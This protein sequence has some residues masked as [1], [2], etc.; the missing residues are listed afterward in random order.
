MLQ[1]PAAQYRNNM[2]AF[3]FAK[4]IQIFRTVGLG[5]ATSV[6]LPASRLTQF[7][8]RQFRIECT[9]LE[10]IVAFLPLASNLVQ[11]ELYY[12]QIVGISSF[13]SNPRC[14]ILP[15]VF[16]FQTGCI[17]V[18]DSVTLPALHA[19]LVESGFISSSEHDYSELDP[20]TLSSIK[21]MLVRSQCQ[22]TLH[23]I[24]FHRITL[25]DDI[26]AII[27][28]SPALDT[29]LLE[30]SGWETEANLVF[31]R[32][33]AELGCTN[34]DGTLSCIPSL[35]LLT[36]HVK[37]IPHHLILSF[38]QDDLVDTMESRVSSLPRMQFNLS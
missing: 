25:T 5:P 36:L 2:Y 1:E 38:Y 6:F 11:V 18:I 12:V 22:N 14:T 17:T 10:Y 30:I 3:E 26:L 35:S 31:Q 8:D 29:M 21:N 20:L 34:S 13:C 4:S 19:L 23:T 32:L 24:E 37:Y 27:Q 7:A 9:T 16:F 28:L 15:R 33:L